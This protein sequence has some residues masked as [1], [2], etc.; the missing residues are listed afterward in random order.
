M[1][2]CALLIAANLVTLA[3]CLENPD[4]SISLAGFAGFAET[5]D[6]DKL[7]YTQEES[8]NLQTSHI[9]GKW[10]DFRIL[11]R[12]YHAYIATFS[13]NHLTFRQSNP[14]GC[15]ALIHAS[16]I[17]ETYSCA[18]ATN[19]GFFIMDNSS[20]SSF[21]LGNIV[22]DTSA[23]V[24]ADGSGFAG[25]NIGISDSHIVT[26]FLNMSVAETFGFNTLITG[27]GWLVRDGVSY[28]AKSADLTNQQKFT[29]EKAPRTT[30]GAFA[31]GTMILL[32]IGKHVGTDLFQIHM[33][34][35]G[36]MCM[37]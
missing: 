16:E 6:F 15:T 36:Y 19:G 8:N 20:A 34:Y 33:P 1:P 28:V 9:T 27:M 12:N 3:L 25:V 24:P 29:T 37:Q 35:F 17:A 22:S 32:E 18:Y 21:C 11:G 4:F 26:G 14:D 30:V 23:Q 13:A 31:N 7:P 10:S 2:L 5:A